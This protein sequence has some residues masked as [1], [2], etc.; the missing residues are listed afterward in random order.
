MGSN[1]HFTN[2]SSHTISTMRSLLS[3]A[4]LAAASVV[5]AVSVTGNRLLVVLDDVAEKES[6]S[7][8]FGSLASSDRGFDITYDT[9]RSEDL[10]L[11]HLGERTYD[12]I[13]FLPTKVKALGPKLTPQILLD[14]VNA[15]GNVM[16]ALS[17]TTP[18]STSTVAFLAELGISLPQE[19]TGLVVDHF[20]YD[21][22]SASEKHD[23]LVLHNSKPVRDDMSDVF[24]LRDDEVLALPHTV[25][26]TLGAGELLT[27]ILRAPS[28]A[29]SYNPK[30]QTDAVDPDD[31][32]A[33]GQQL[34]LASAFQARNSARVTVLGSAE[35]LQDK[36]LDAKV[37][38][39]G[40]SKVS[41]K[42]AEFAKTLTGWTFQELGVLRVD[43]IE[44]RLKDSNETNPE[45]YRIKNEVHY[46][47][48]L[49]EYRWDAWVPFNANPND[50]PQ[51]EVSMLSP[52]HRLNLAPE[53]YSAT[54]GACTYS[55]D[56]ILPDQHGIFNLRVNYKRPF[57]TYIDEKRTVSVRHMAHDEWPRSFVISGAWPWISGIGA[58]VSGFVM[59]C[60]IWVYS[61]PAPPLVKKTQ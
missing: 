53:E 51:L 10:Q 50:P 2:D 1:S 5:S 19:R 18:A 61:K 9:P 25:G 6:Y 7:K 26:H 20:N 47:I 38:L 8:L 58:T 40:G 24:S 21:T 60:A 37:A 13:V 17:A 55:T 41:T 15:A 49:S 3:L 16:V 12:H 57:Y 29:Y 31:L 4:V 45:I 43:E 28:T 46:Q 44:H 30:E 56:L 52:F 22:V 36:W 34:A 48:S 27:P 39:E 14:F 54:D 42:N 59:F 33:V 32:F 23:T 35:M 11:F